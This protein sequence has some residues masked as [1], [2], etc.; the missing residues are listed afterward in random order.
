LRGALNPKPANTAASH[1]IKTTKKDVEIELPEFW[2][3]RQ[4]T[5]MSCS[6]WAIQVEIQSDLSR[7]LREEPVY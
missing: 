6:N 4:R 7:F 2:T 5:C 1:N 3:I